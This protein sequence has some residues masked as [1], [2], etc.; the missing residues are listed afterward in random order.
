MNVPRRRHPRC[1]CE[2]SNSIPV[3]Q[4][5][6]QMHLVHFE[7]WANA[8]ALEQLA[9][10]GLRFGGKRLLEIGTSSACTMLCNHF[11][12]LGFHSTHRDVQSIFAFI[13]AIH[14]VT[15]RKDLTTRNGISP[16]C[17]MSKNVWGET[18]QR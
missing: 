9:P 13:C 11:L 1:S 7:E 16:S 12:E 2:S 8:S 3:T 5:G 6:V 15:A 4:L 10:L 18:G 17:G 14:R